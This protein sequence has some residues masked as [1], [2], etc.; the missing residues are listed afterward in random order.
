MT[1]FSPKIWSFARGT[2]LPI[3]HAVNAVSLLGPDHVG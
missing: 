2:E 1:R 3:D